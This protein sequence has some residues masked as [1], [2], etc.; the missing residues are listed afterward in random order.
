MSESELEVRTNIGFDS[1]SDSDQNSWRNS[2]SK[3]RIFQ[4]C[5]SRNWSRSQTELEPSEVLH[6]PN[7]NDKIWK[8]KITYQEKKIIN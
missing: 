3:L 6:S 7:L 1:N 8:M 5:Q 4:L 2:G